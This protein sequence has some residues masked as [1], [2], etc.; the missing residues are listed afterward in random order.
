M[1]SRDPWW[2]IVI[3][4]FG[5]IVRPAPRYEH[6]FAEEVPSWVPAPDGSHR[7]LFDGVFVGAESPGARMTNGITVKKEL[8][9]QQVLHVEICV[10]G[11]CYRTSMDLGPAIA[12][13]LQKLAQW[14]QD[15]HAPQPSPATVVS[16]VGRTVAAAGDA[17]VGTMVGHYA[18][19]TVGSWLDDVGNAIGGTLRT[20]Q[21]VIS[22]VATGVA[23]A[24][25]GPAAG[26]AA[27]QLVPMWTG[28]QADLLDP[29][30]SPK[31]KA[32]AAQ[33]MQ[34]VAQVAATNPTA[35]QALSAAHQAVKNTTIA[36]H[37]QD[38]AQKAAAGDPAAQQSINQLVQAAEQGDPTAKSTWEVLV[39]TFGDQLMHSDAGAK[40]WQQITGP[41]P[42][43][44]AVSGWYDIVG[45]AVDDVRARA[46]TVATSN[47]ADVV[48]VLRTSRGNWRTRAF[49]DADAADDW[50]GAATREP[51]S[52]TYAAIFDKTD[53]LW[54]HPLNEKIGEAAA[55]SPAGA[56]IQRGIATTMGR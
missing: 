56:P 2:P 46:Q 13:V 3:N 17:I 15:Q 5:D 44:P 8:D 30:G 49:R 39:K 16:T 23:T 6:P 9:D 50:L 45:A 34:R 28:M 43:G 31:K 42:G 32:Q 12:M 36:Y 55:A 10:D 21:P 25:G 20:L 47:N 4:A 24:F 33:A 14:H 29:K 19:V 22:T 48:G 53:V 52:Y 40:L 51:S 54:P 1:N 38:Q 11:K 35:Q 41:G 37:V 26:A 7:H 27:G 18:G